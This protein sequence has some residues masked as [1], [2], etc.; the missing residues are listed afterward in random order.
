MFRGF[1]R[2]KLFFLFMEGMIWIFLVFFII[3]KILINGFLN[4]LR[5]LE[6]LGYENSEIKFIVFKFA[7]EIFLI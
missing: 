6:F 4:F 3:L 7:I 2:Y 1:F 5:N